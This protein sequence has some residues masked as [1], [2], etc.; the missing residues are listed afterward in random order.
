M[1]LLL[2]II[3]TVSHVYCFH[4]IVA[5]V[6]IVLMPLVVVALGKLL[7]LYCCFHCH[8]ALLLCCLG[9]TIFF[10]VFSLSDWCLD[11]VIVFLVPL[12]LLIAV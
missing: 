2:F 9:I 1:I 11:V 4:A 8:A 6:A 10:G 7:P 3:A 12:L 5:V